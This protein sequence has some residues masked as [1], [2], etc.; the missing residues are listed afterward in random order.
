MRRVELDAVPEEVAAVSADASV[1]A[2]RRVDE[3]D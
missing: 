3:G 2:L 1:E